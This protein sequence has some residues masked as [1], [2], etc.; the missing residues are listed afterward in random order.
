MLSALIIPEVKA[1]K[2]NRTAAS[3]DESLN[4]TA[5]FPKPVIFP[6]TFAE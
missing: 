1:S 6:A 5:S 2:V 4:V 3:I